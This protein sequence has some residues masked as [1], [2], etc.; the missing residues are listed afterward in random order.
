MDKLNILWTTDNKYEVF[1]MLNLYASRSE[2]NDWWNDV[3]LIIW[4]ASAKLVGTDKKVQSEIVEMINQGVH[5]EAFKDSCD[6]FGVS[7]KLIE[8]GINV[9]Y[10]GR[11]L[12]EYIQSGQKIVTM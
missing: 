11:P 2:K 1:S 8:L 5:V 3:N 7:E 9:R 10:M 4:G 6:K 12:T